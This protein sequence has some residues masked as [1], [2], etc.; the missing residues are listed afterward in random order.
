[1]N[2]IVTI[3]LHLQ[4]LL[5][6][7]TMVAALSCHAATT[8]S[9]DDITHRNIQL[10]QQW[11]STE[12]ITNNKAAIEAWKQLLD[13]IT[14]NS[15]PTPA[16]TR[17]NAEQI[18]FTKL[19]DSITNENH[20]QNNIGEITQLIRSWPR[21]EQGWA[22]ILIANKSIVIDSN[23]AVAN[24]YQAATIVNNNH[25]KNVRQYSY[26]A[27]AITKLALE[28]AAQTAD[29]KPD[30]LN[31]AQQMISL[32]VSA[33]HRAEAMHLLAKASIGNLST[34]TQTQYSTLHKKL[35]SILAKSPADKTRDGKLHK[36]H[37]AAM[38][39][40]NHKIAL[41]AI[42]GMFDSKYSQ[43]LLFTLARTALKQYDYNLANA[44]AKRISD[45]LYGSYIW[46]ELAAYHYR[47]NRIDKAKSALSFSLQAAASETKPK[48]ALK[49][50]N[51]YNKYAN[52][53]DM[54]PL[55]LTENTNNNYHISQTN[56]TTA[57][58]YA[59]ALLSKFTPQEDKNIF[60]DIQKR[61]ENLQKTE[62]GT[63]KR[64]CL[65]NDISLSPPPEPI[66]GLQEKPGYGGD[67]RA[68]K[69]TWQVMILG[70]RALAGD[71][72]SS[73]KL[74][75]LLINWAQADALLAS[76]Q[77]I[78]SYYALKRIM[79]P[80]IVNYSII[81]N[82]LTSTQRNLIENWID[83]LVRPLNKYFGG[84]DIDR[85]NH[86]QLADATLMAWGAY[87]GD[88]ELYNIGISG[89][90]KL[91]SSAKPNGELPL[92]S[93][94]GARAT[95]YIR[96]VLSSIAVIQAIAQTH[97]HYSQLINNSKTSID[98]ILHYF[99]NAHFAPISI[100]PSA[101]ENLKPGPN[102][103]YLQFDNGYI[104]KRGHGRHYMAFA[105]FI[106][107]SNSFAAKRLKQLMENTSFAERP[108]ID[109]YIGGNA[110][111]FF[112]EPSR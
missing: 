110:T 39:T 94:R 13:S 104:Y 103:N 89:L 54:Q 3:T 61:R 47:N 62:Y 8:S 18:L 43:K 70:G 26:M 78:D 17:K 7:F 90:Y 100:L 38:K 68:N 36:L 63:I 32:I 88:K 67:N 29:I 30:M 24:L 46:G 6:L 49:A 93:R 12:A 80:V 102:N 10:Q 64:F 83:K 92:E 96:H 2:Y 81:A 95:W 109:E 58:S 52:L 99:L 72:K 53:L 106:S 101:A 79:L 105:E 35:L 14:N 44:I 76:D 108:L 60:F 15:M 107:K 22:Y 56:Q 33:H 87:T 1:M 16:V 25:A 48:R 50:I 111:C 65:A 75:K 20:L 112:M 57:N 84:A 55:P 45:G 71:E 98:G 97:N 66:A 40:G 74:G 27:H 21:N 23:I 37:I 51:N 9:T 31:L 4:L 19:L 5:S 73:V 86:R 11:L 59:N 69:F 42:S 82:N 85:N 28:I 91:I 41:D 77:S 34:S